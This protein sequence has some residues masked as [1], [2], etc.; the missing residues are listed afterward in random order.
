VVSQHT[1]SFWANAVGLVSARSG[2]RYCRGSSHSD[3]M[4]NR[5]IAWTGAGDSTGPWLGGYKGTGRS[6][7]RVGEDGSWQ[8]GKQALSVWAAALGAD[9]LNSSWGKSVGDSLFVISDKA[10]LV[11]SWVIAYDNEHANQHSV[12]LLWLNNNM[13]YK[14]YKSKMADS[15]VTCETWRYT[16][17]L[18]WNWGRSIKCSHWIRSLIETCIH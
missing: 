11:Q 17:P 14:C 8:H 18:A 9:S 6:R 4:S 16:V 2:S 1:C 15:G 13:V 12:P 5:G 3:S 10:W 7:K